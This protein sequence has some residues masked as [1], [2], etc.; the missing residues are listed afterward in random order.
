MR[1]ERGEEGAAE[2]PGASGGR[3]DAAGATEGRAAEPAEG[4]LTL[5]CLKCGKEVF[6]DEGS[7]PAGLT[8]EK[9]GGSVFRDFFSS[10]GDEA[11]DDFRETTERDLDTD[12]AEG[13]TLPGDLIDLNRGG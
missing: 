9:C 8:C 12:D 7:P 11:S 3:D 13:D 4:V 1:H 6:F 2:G 5:V 10:E